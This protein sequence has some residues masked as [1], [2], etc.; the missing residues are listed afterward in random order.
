MLKS[1]R[2]HLQDATPIRL[3]QEF[4]GYAA[5][6]A[7]GIERVEVVESELLELALGGTAV[8]TGINAPDG[9]AAGTIEIMNRRS[10]HSFREA[11]NHFEA[12]ASKDAYVN[13]SGVLK[14]VATS[15]FKGHQENT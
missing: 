13:A 10:G 1:G 9:F 11:D 14:T 3:G 2:T 12:Q 4:S 5:Q 15:L 7:K 8:G 6:V